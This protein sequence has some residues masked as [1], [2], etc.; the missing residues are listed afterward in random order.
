MANFIT[1]A[2]QVSRCSIKGGRRHYSDELKNKI[3]MLAK[4]HGMANVATK[5]GVRASLIHR[6]TKKL[7][8]KNNSKVVQ[9]FNELSL[10]ELPQLS[11]PT[12]ENKKTPVISLVSSTGVRMEINLSQE[13]L[14]ELINNFMG[15]QK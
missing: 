4:T 13:N 11:I 7:P 6:W 9:R 5:I 14:S 1:L 8:K 2:R 3:C 15:V 10:Q 12:F